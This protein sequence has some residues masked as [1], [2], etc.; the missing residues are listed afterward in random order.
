MSGTADRYKLSAALYNSQYNDFIY[1]H[2]QERD[3]S[4]VKRV[5]RVFF[6]VKPNPSEV[7]R[8]LRL[9]GSR[10]REQTP[11][12]AVQTLA[13]SGFLYP[14]LEGEAPAELCKCRRMAREPGLFNDLHQVSVADVYYIGGSMA[15]QGP[16][17]DFA[18]ILFLRKRVFL[19]S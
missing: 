19:I 13:L 18:I 16:K 8:A 15:L 3:Y 14:L 7:S 2:N 12:A 17:T 1:L 5:E 6:A 9:T 4:L 11:F 10:G